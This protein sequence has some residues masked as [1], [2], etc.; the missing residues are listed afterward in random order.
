MANM[1]L[2]GKSC[3][4][5]RP[6]WVVVVFGVLSLAGFGGQGV[7][8]ADKGTLT[9]YS[10]VTRDG[11]RMVGWT[12]GGHTTYELVPTNQLPANL[13]PVREW[14]IYCV[15]STHTDIGLHNSQ[16]V[17]RHGSVTRTD[18]ARKLVAA[19]PNDADMAAFRYT[20][21][22]YWFFHNYPLDRGEDATRALIANEM[23]R[24]RIGTTA[25]CAGNHTHLYGYEELCRSIYTRKIYAEKWGLN[26]KTLHP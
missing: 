7:V 5:L 15:R 26:P 14:K 3:A 9:A 25:A 16:Y 2:D 17:Q 12:K 19:E 23:R 11:R 8:P 20:L 13:P 1:V 6:M 4:A 10:M 21:E 18:L 22:G 24:G